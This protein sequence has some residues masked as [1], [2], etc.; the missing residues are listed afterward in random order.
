PSGNCGNRTG[1]AMSVQLAPTDFT[2]WKLVTLRAP[3]AGEARTRFF[4]LPAL[5]TASEIVLQT[6]HPG[7]FSTPAFFANWPT[8]SSNQMRV[9]LNQALI[10]AT[11]T[12][13]DGTDSTTPPTTPGLDGDHAPPGTACFGC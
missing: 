9:T 8:N 5:R 12:A 7:F 10:V 6:P 13:I 2:S 1:S 11:G 3:R 4:D